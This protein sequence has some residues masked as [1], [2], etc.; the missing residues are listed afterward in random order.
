[1]VF[2]LQLLLSVQTTPLNDADVCGNILL[3]EKQQKRLV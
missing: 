2:H 3:H 1:M